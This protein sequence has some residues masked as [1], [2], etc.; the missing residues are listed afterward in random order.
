M[1]AAGGLASLE[2]AVWANPKNLTPDNGPPKVNS[3]II[4]YLADPIK[5]NNIICFGLPFRATQHPAE[6]SQC[7]LIQCHNCQHF[8]HTAVQCSSPPACGRCAAPHATTDCRCP[9]TPPCEDYRQC[10]HIALSCALCRSNHHASYCDCPSQLNAQCRL[11]E[12]G[13]HDDEYYHTPT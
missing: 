7:S 3:S 6:K 1:A 9:E 5:V 8:R 4:I 13:L 2:K 11:Q 10:N 12:L